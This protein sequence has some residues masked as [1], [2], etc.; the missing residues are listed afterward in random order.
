MQVIS[1]CFGIVNHFAQTGI[2]TIVKV[3]EA[4]D[5]A[6]YLPDRVPLVSNAV[7]TAQMFVD[8]G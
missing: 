6:H 7:G 3:T 1:G 8:M 5:R 2:P 4:V